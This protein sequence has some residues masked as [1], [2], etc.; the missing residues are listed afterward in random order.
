MNCERVRTDLAAYV[1]GDLPREA[2]DA[3]AAHLHQCPPC[4][5][6]AEVMR[7]LCHRLA[8]G[9]KAWAEVGV[10]PPDLEDRLRSAVWAESA[11]ASA[12][13][14]VRIRGWVAAAGAAAMVACL[15]L[16]VV[17]A[18]N[19]SVTLPLL[20]GVIRGW[21]GQR[22]GPAVWYPLEA[23]ASRDGVTLQAVA[24]AFAGGETLCRLRVRGLRPG[25]GESWRQ[26]SLVL[27]A[28][29][30][31]VPMYALETEASAA[32]GEWVALKA[33]FGPVPVDVPI[34]L[35]VDQLAGR[36]GPWELTLL[37]RKQ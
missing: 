5:A 10:C 22:T 16:I 25:G 34:R 1:A 9:L 35:R 21:R 13:R 30:Q 6:E 23:S 32:D 28:G 36:A 4:T 2:R 12:A 29:E 3:I 33:T 24:T 27:V 26:S 18:L 17:P 37:Q 14:R 31:T 11:A 19:R 7:G 20:Q 15:T 8:C